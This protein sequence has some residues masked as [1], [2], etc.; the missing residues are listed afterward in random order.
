M[1]P[2]RHLAQR[3]SRVFSSANSNCCGCLLLLTFLSC[4]AGSAAT[5]EKPTAPSLDDAK[6]N[7]VW[8]MYERNDIQVIDVESG[9]IGRSFLR[10]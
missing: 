1:M 4:V 8:V 3:S 9:D 10:L 5:A 2:Q 7:K 6:Y